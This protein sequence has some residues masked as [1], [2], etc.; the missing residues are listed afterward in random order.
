M[1]RCTIVTKNEE[2]RIPHAHHL[3]KR[4]GNTENDRPYELTVGPENDWTAT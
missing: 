4:E 1:I 2:K 3:V